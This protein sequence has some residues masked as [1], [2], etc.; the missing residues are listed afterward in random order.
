MTVNWGKKYKPE[1]DTDRFEWSLFLSHRYL[2]CLKQ[3]CYV[4]FIVSQSLEFSDFLLSLIIIITLAFWT[5]KMTKA[6]NHMSL[7]A[8]LMS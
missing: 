8:Y 6:I 2:K 1:V 4:S 3:S 5:Y 7:K